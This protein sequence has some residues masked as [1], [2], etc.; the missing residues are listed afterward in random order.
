MCFR[1]CPRTR[2][3]ELFIF[4]QSAADTLRSWLLRP[5]HLQSFVFFWQV[6]LFRLRY[7]LSIQS[8][9]SR[10]PHCRYCCQNHFRPPS[11]CPVPN[12]I[13]FSVKVWKSPPNV[14]FVQVWICKSPQR[15]CWPW[16]GPSLHKAIDRK[17]NVCGDL[18][19]RRMPCWSRRI[20]VDFID[21]Y[22]YFSGGIVKLTFCMRF[23]FHLM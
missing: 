11:F 10:L 4:T 22:H 3:F 21:C 12:S 2:L 5:Y 17:F 9:P 13:S 6:F 7:D 1:F 19:Y 16:W 14:G 23:L 20:F 15:C 8:I 18:K